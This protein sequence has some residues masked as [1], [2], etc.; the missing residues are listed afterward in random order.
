VNRNFPSPFAARRTR[1]SP[2]GSLPRLSVRHGLDCSM[3]SLVSALPSTSSPRHL[4]AL[5]RMLR[6]Y[7]SAVR[8]PAAVHVGIIAHRFPPPARLFSSAGSDWASRFSRVE[9]LYRRGVFDSAGSR[10]TCVSARRL[11]AFRLGRHRRLP[12]FPFSELIIQPAYAPAQRF[13]GSLAAALA[14][15]GVRMVRYAFPV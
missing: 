5:V 13:A 7:Y 4:P 2:L 9:F 14:W 10:R 15:L 6:R 1:S 8:L 11:V 3:F 12:A